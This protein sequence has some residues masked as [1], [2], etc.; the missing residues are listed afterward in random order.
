MSEFRIDKFKLVLDGAQIVLD[1]LDSAFHLTHHRV[2][3]LALRREETEVVLIR[4]ELVAL[5][6][7][8][9]DN[10][11]T[12]AAQFGGIGAH[13]LHHILEAAHAG[14]FLA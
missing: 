9:A 8:G 14:T 3:A 5:D 10:A 1:T 2:A 4:L 7:V 13:L 6:F 12:F 11:L